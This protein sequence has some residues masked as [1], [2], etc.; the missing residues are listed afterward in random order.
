MSDFEFFMSDASWGG[1]SSWLM[2]PWDSGCGE[3]NSWVITPWA[4]RGR[5][6]CWGSLEFID[7]QKTHKC[8]HYTRL[9][10]W[11]TE[12]YETKKNVWMTKRKIGIRNTFQIENTLILGDQL[13]R[14]HLRPS[15]RCSA[16]FRST[17]LG[18][19]RLI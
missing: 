15:D 18:N 17:R 2:P 4:S 7:R 11:T 5:A 19:G 14:N 6:S 8:N 13:P 1:L 12:N 3:L 16:G 10:T 9:K